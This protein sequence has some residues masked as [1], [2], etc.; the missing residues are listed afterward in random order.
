MDLNTLDLFQNGI[1]AFLT[2]PFS[3]SSL[4][5][6]GLSNIFSSKVFDEY[7]HI[8][9]YCIHRILL[10]LLMFDFISFGAFKFI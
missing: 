9:Y 6:L 1:V 8:E 10:S 2:F 4:G 3:L 5:A 7:R